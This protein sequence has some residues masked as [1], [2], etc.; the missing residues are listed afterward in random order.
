MAPI[1]ISTLQLL[2]WMLHNYVSGPIARRCA[3][4]N[5]VILSFLWSV[6]KYEVVWRLLGQKAQVLVF[7]LR[8]EMRIVRQVWKSSLHQLLHLHRTFAIFVT[9]YVYSTII[10][11]EYTGLFSRYGTPMARILL[12][13]VVVSYVHIQVPHDICLCGRP[14]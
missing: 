12:V 4:K 1:S 3:Q 7:P 2:K 9:L 8:I 6:I 11:H 13:C 5:H 14:Q 10:V